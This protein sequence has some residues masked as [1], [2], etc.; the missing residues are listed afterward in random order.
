MCA[1]G[2]AQNARC[3]RCGGSGWFRIPDVGYGL[4][5][6][7]M[8]TCINCNQYVNKLGHSCRCTLCGRQKPSQGPGSGRDGGDSRTTVSEEAVFIT[9]CLQMNAIPENQP[10][11]ACGGTGICTGCKGSGYIVMGMNMN[12]C[13]ACSMTRKCRTC[14]GNR[15]VQN[16]R[17]MT[18]QERQQYT[19]ALKRQME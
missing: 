4:N 19:D 17:P 2:E 14:G 16:Y 3:G 13:P 1:V 8:G 10:C 12:P 9:R 7:V 11:W 5:D 6:K 15:I 18:P